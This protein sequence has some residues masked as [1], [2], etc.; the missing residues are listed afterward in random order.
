MLILQRG[1]SFDSPG[2]ATEQIKAQA[3]TTEHSAAGGRL[4]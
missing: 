4:D 3:R 1:N 2:R